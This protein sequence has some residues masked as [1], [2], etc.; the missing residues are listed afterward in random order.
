MAADAARRRQPSLATFGLD[1]SG[2]LQVGPTMSH[3]PGQRIDEASP[4]NPT[5]QSQTLITSVAVSLLAGCAATPA[6]APAATA[7][8]KTVEAPATDAN[9]PPPPPGQTRYK[10]SRATEADVAAQLDKKFQEAAKAYVQLK[11]ND[12]VMFCKK[13]REMGS[14]IRTL[15]C[16]TEAE[17]RKQVEDSD[18]VRN[19]MRH[20]MGKCD[21]TVGCSG[22]G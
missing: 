8:A 16:I 1:A 2:L 7:P 11:R 14:S 18:Q 6:G 10:W 4:M 19:Q 3:T 20:K 13:Y 9:K 12:Q 17:L 22:G 15:H 21:I 5:G